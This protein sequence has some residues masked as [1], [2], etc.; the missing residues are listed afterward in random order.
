MF[1][2]RK[3]HLD[4]VSFSKIVKNAGTYL[5]L[6]LAVF[7]MVFF[8]ICSPRNKLAGGGLH[9]TAARVNGEDISGNEFRRA[10]QSNHDQYSRQFGADFDPGMLRLAEMTMNQL[11]DQ[12][13]EVEFASSLGV[14]VG[15]QEIIERLGK[16]PY[17]KDSNGKFSSE[18]F[19]QFLSRSGYSEATLL[20][21]QRR[22]LVGSRAQQIIGNMVYISPAEAKLEY[23]LAQTKRQYEFI[24]LDAKSIKPQVSDKDV[25]TYLAD[26]ANQAKLEEEYAKRSHEFNQAERLQ[27]R[28]ILIAFKGARNASGVAAERSK[29]D[30][31]NLAELALKQVQGAGV[32]FAKIAS[33]MTDEPSGKTKGGDL[34]EFSKEDMVKEFSDAAF[35]LQPGQIAAAPV[36]SPFGF[37]IIKVEG[38]TPAKTISLDAAKPIIARDLLTRQQAPDLIDTV[39]K[40]LLAALKANNEVKVQEIM[41]NWNMKWENTGMIALE[42]RSIPNLGTSEELSKVMASLDEK[43]KLADQLVNVNDAKFVLRFQATQAADMQAFTPQEAERY[44]QGLARARG[45]SIYKELSQKYKENLEKNGNIWKNSDY[46]AIDQ[47]REKNDAKSPK[48]G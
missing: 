7:A 11:I 16:E 9:G 18:K 43:N 15:D 1:D 23:Q 24:R 19:E 39:G 20:D 44:T 3:K 38:R 5:V 13:L 30:A 47:E 33:E 22:A 8:G 12:R 31:K 10:Y 26:K 40:D 35:A 28:H 42:A 4:E 36:E 27:A 37:H 21:E 29:E 14:V 25:Q 2:L 48:K 6:G 34:G 46:L 41:K 17:F 32:D 45:Y